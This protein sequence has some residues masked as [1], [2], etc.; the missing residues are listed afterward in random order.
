MRKLREGKKRKRNNTK[1]MYLNFFNSSSVVDYFHCFLSTS[2]SVVEADTNCT[3]ICTSRI[4]IYIYV[5][6]YIILD[7]SLSFSINQIRMGTKEAD[8]SLCK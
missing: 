3:S 8:H 4:Y 5:C 1:L 2:F 6:I 7:I